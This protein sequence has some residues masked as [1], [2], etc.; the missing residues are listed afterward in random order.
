[1]T[2]PGQNH[3]QSVA[4]LDLTVMAKLF[5][6]LKIIF[7]AWHTAWPTE[8]QQQSARMEWL[9]AFGENGIA[10]RE[11]LG[12]G[13]TK[14]RAHNSDFLPSVGTFIAWCKVSATDLCLPDADE[15]ARMASRRDPLAPAAVKLAA[16]ACKWLSSNA[17]ADEWGKEFKRKYAELVERAAKGGDLDAEWQA[18]KG[19][20][21]IEHKPAELT[22]DERLAILAKY[23]PKR[24]G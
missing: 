8:R 6:Q 19:Q 15:A 10:T 13:L 20:K 2:I 23:R 1:M 24:G 4:A 9:K 12:R 18:I 16:R 21:G 17:R 14:A 3:Q 22:E 11:Q 7:P 5:E